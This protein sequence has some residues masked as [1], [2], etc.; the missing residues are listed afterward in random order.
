L[1]NDSKNSSSSGETLALGMYDKNLLLSSTSQLFAS[2]ALLLLLLL[3]TLP[4]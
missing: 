1:E 2:Y 4:W 3:L